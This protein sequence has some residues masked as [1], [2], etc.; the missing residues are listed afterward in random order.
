LYYGFNTAK[1]GAAL[2]IFCIIL[3]A[4]DRLARWAYRT[5]RGSIEYWN[6]EIKDL[7]N[8]GLDPDQIALEEDEFVNDAEGWESPIIE[9]RKRHIKWITD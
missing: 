4:T 2:G 6:G 7:K 5:V 1:V 8:G 3:T 9:K